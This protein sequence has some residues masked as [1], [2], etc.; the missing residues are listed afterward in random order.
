MRRAAKARKSC[1]KK[2]GIFAVF[3]HM[4]TPAKEKKEPRKKF[5]FSFFS[6]F[7]FFFKGKSEKK[8]KFQG[9]GM[10]S[11]TPLPSRNFPRGWAPCTSANYL[12]RLGVTNPNIYIFLFKNLV[13]G[14]FV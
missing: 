10:T 3:L 12:V 9:D 13:W 5:F 11:T 4:L 6:F 7:F 14:S 2:G 8:K 1:A